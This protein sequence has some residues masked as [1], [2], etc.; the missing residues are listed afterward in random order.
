MTNQLIKKD[1]VVSFP[2]Y[3]N[4]IIFVFIIMSMLLLKVLIRRKLLSDS[5]S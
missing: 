1:I 4:I 3:S 5:I 2:D